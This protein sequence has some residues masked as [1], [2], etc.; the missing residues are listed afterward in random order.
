MV[1]KQGRSGTSLERNNGHIVL[2]VKRVYSSLHMEELFII[3]VTSCL[4]FLQHRIL[5]RERMPSNFIPRRLFL[6]RTCSILRSPKMHFEGWCPLKGWMKQDIFIGEMKELW[7]SYI[8][9][10][11]RSLLVQFRSSLISR[12]SKLHVNE[13]RIGDYFTIN[14]H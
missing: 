3:S 8:H 4:A 5:A 9:R 6:S 1:H 7:Q 12:I 14:I 10:N 11:L 13:Q 2:F